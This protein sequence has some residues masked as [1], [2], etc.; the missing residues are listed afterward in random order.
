MDITHVGGWSSMFGSL[1]YAEQITWVTKFISLE[2]QFWLHLSFVMQPKWPEQLLLAWIT[3]MMGCL[4][5]SI[6]SPPTVEIRLTLVTTLKRSPL[7]FNN[8]V[9][10]VWLLVPLIPYDGAMLLLMFQ[11]AE[12]AALQGISDIF[13]WVTQGWSQWVSQ[14]VDED[15]W[16]QCGESVP[17]QMNIYDGIQGVKGSWVDLGDVVIV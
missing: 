13:K 9:R 12:R 2:Q 5:F 4:T 3:T 1:E 7:P 8:T 16:A 11:P 6:H 15:I 10:V 17:I 14:Q